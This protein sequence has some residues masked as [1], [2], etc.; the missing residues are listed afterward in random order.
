MRRI[1][2]MAIAAFLAAVMFYLSR[3]W[4]LSLW[5]R[6]GLFGIEELRPQGGLL[7]RWLRGTE[8][9]QFELII[10]AIGCFLVLTFAQ[11]IYD[12]LTAHNDAGDTDD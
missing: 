8:A 1:I 6:S 9:A 3:F 7:A 2:T 12:R 11:S 10:W 5:P 4:F